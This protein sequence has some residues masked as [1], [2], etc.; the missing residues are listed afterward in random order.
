MPG[1]GNYERT[2]VC[3]FD[4]GS[5]KKG[6]LGKLCCKPS[7]LNYCLF[8]RHD[9][10]KHNKSLG[11]WCGKFLL[12]KI[13]RAYVASNHGGATSEEM[14]SRLLYRQQA[15][16]PQ[17]EAEPKCRKW[18]PH[19]C[20]LLCPGGLAPCSAASVCRDSNLS[21]CLDSLRCLNS[22][23][24]DPNDR[25]AHG[26]S[27][28][29]TR[30]CRNT[31]TTS[32]EP[33]GHDHQQQQQQQLLNIASVQREST[34]GLTHTAPR[35]RAAAV[36]EAV[37]TRVSR[38]WERLAGLFCPYTPF[39]IFYKYTLLVSLSCASCRAI[40]STTTASRKTLTRGYCR[41]QE[42]RHYHTVAVLLYRCIMNI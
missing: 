23:R 5:Q 29:P 25:K 10:P 11:S 39:F 19:G 12:R 15:A 30:V 33:A 8:P 42:E 24:L 17:A 35:G 22:N 34:A 13:L 40:P 21:I 14:R 31:A 9:L 1:T 37:R 26:S 36:V 20:S 41:T 6:A 2:R 7:L 18:E 3:S 4:G 32:A 28:A 27:H 16:E 38:G